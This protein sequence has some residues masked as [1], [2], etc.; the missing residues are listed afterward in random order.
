MPAPGRGTAVLHLAE[1]VE[2]AGYELRV[3]I[4]GQTYWLPFLYDT[5]T[6]VGS[7]VWVLFAGRTG[8]VLGGIGQCPTPE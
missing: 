1:V 5:P 7:L 4:G 6:A 3:T 8:L 2:C